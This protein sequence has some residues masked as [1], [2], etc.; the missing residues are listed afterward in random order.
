MKCTDC[1]YCWA[2]LDE[3]GR[4]VS[5]RYCHFDGPDGWAPCEIVEN[6]D[7]DWEG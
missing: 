4:P 1:A 3:E 5:Y 7:D 2:D 6:W